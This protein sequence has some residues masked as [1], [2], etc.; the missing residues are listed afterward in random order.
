MQACADRIREFFRNGGTYNAT[1]AAHSELLSQNVVEAEFAE[2]MSIY[3]PET[4][5]VAMYAKLND[6]L[7]VFNAKCPQV[8]AIV[9]GA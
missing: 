8:R 5:L 9:K 2:Y 6:N 1:D 4:Q 3:P 7:A